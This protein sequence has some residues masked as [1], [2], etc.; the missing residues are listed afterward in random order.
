MPG[1]EEAPG[2]YL[3]DFQ[4]ET[5]KGWDRSE[6]KGKEEKCVTLSESFYPLVLTVFLGVW[7][8]KEVMLKNQ[9]RCLSSVG[10][11]NMLFL[12]TEGGCWLLGRFREGLGLAPALL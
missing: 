2:K 3:L 1:T 8:L 11:L 9:A 7:G 4:N 5:G 12:G 6:K 10:T